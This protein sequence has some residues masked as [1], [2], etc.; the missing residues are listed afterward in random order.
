MFHVEHNRSR[1]MVQA[2]M[3]HVEH[4]GTDAVSVQNSGP[5]NCRLKRRGKRDGQVP[6]ERIALYP[7]PP[8]RHPPRSTM[9]SWSRAS[10]SQRFHDPPS[11]P[12]GSLT[13]RTPSKARRGAAHSAVG[14]GAAKDRAVTRPA[15]PRRSPR[16]TETA[17][18]A[19]TSTRSAMPSSRTAHRRNVHRRSP[20][21]TRTHRFDVRVARTSPG[22]PPPVP[23]STAIV[24][25]SR[26]TGM[27]E[28]TSGPGATPGSPS[29]PK[30]RKPA[31]CAGPSAAARGVRNPSATAASRIS[32]TGV[33]TRW[34]RP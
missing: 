32:S 27:P 28:A 13:T 6:V 5:A 33:V 10:G 11:P 3:F 18:M 15:L 1:T 22:T 2:P 24:S 30:R 16:A 12:G 4:V 9:P 34:S 31:L 20:R 17:S 21:S 7:A 19:W 29:P 14:P 8:W 23:R 26:S 25:A